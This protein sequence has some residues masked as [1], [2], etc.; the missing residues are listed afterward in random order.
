MYGTQSL[1]PDGPPCFCD[2]QNGSTTAPGMSMGDGA[3][4][5][6]TPATAT[7]TGAGPVPAA[8]TATPGTPAAGS[9][10]QPVPLPTD[11]PNAAGVA[12]APWGVMT[13]VTQ[14]VLVSF[15]PCL[16]M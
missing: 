4:G 1:I 7:A 12:L 3:A 2:L 8:S 15:L 14:L 9:K 5:G 10:A 16:L 6:T 13:V 11:V